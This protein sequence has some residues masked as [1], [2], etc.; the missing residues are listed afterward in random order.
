VHTLRNE[1]TQAVTALQQAKDGLQALEPNN[2]AARHS[3]QLDLIFSLQ[4]AGQAE[5]A[6]REGAALL[7]EA[8]AQRQPNTLLVALAQ[9]SMAR[10]QG[11][12]HAQAE[13]LLLQ[14]QPVIAAQLGE[15]HSR[16]LTLLNELMGA[17]MR[18]GDWAK[19]LPYGEQVHQRAL[20]KLGEQHPVTFV[21]LTNWARV[22]S[23]AGQAA[24]ALPKAQR[25]HQ[26]L[27]ALLGPKAAQF[28]D[29][30]T[31]LVQIELQLGMADQALGHVAQLDAA[32]LEASRA[33]GV[34]PHV[35]DAMRG[36]ALQ[37]RGDRAAARPLLDAALLALK[38]EEALDTPSQVYVMAKRARAR[39]L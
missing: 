6:R 18:R 35:I 11:E 30:T 16:Y 21:T 38:D 7:Q 2:V 14:A 19:A 27:Q 4:M 24:Q 29:A 1:F 23:E 33:N 8:Q 9:A 20:A 26:Q 17:A 34:W 32:A 10:A 15:S 31:V 13:R 36:V 25:A 37:Q 12:D 5:D 22:M 28:Q 39:L 3:V